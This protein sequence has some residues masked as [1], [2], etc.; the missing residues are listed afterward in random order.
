MEL[1]VV[2]DKIKG[3][4]GKKK[5]ELQIENEELIRSLKSYSGDDPAYVETQKTIQTNLD[6]IER[7]RALEENKLK[8]TMIDPR[9]VASIIASA[10]YIGS[11]TYAAWLEGN[12]ETI[13]HLW[14][15][16]GPKGPKI[17]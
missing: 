1:N 12:G 7:M 13:S 16:Y 10:A 8:A 11:L 6:I 4:F 17:L 2:T 3:I 14:H 15:K 9:V 5:S